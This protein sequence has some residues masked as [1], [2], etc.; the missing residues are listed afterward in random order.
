MDRPTPAELAFAADVYARDARLRAYCLEQGFTNKRSGATSYL[1][2][3]VAHLNPPTNEERSRA[4]QIRFRAEPPT[5]PYVAYLSRDASRVTTWMD[6]TLAEVANLTT[7]R[8]RNSFTTDERGTFVARGIDG[9]VYHGT[10]NG[11]GMYCRMCPAK[12]SART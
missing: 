8:V 11:A 2:E 4:E 12:M 1:P 7:Y 9:R 6:D 10:H 5:G 3:Q